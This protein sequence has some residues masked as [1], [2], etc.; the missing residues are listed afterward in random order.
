MAAATLVISLEL[1]KR[2]ETYVPATTAASGIPNDVPVMRIAVAYL[3]HSIPKV[4]RTIP[5]T[6]SPD[7][8]SIDIFE[9]T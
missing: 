6:P 3:A 5:I 7:D 8:R 4:L 9:N 1:G 2:V